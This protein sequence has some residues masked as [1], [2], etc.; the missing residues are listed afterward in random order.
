ML[1]KSRSDIYD[2]LYGLFYGTVTE[3]VYSMSEP[4]ELED[5]DRTDGFI[6]LHV[7]NMYDNSEFSGQTYGEV[8]CYVEAYI[9]PVTR[10]RLDVDKYREYEEAITQTI[11]NAIA[12]PNQNEDYC[13][14]E[15]SLISSETEEV[16][17]ANNIFF[18]FIKS[19]IVVINKN[20]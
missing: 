13:I 19:F 14:Q 18:V 11:E 15:D 8:R 9:P 3:N 5:T 12:S 6:V 16:T 2:Y 4:Q 10:G 1:N 17:N 7:G 20:I